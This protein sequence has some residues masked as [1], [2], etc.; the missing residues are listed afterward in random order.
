MITP[1][2]QIHQRLC[3]PGYFKKF[4]IDLDMKVFGKP[5]RLKDVS[6]VVQG[7]LNHE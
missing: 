6:T 3:Q 1:L 5:F 4:D 7:A 2:A